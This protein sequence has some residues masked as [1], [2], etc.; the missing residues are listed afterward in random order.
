VGPE[1]VGKNGI[2]TDLAAIE[3]AASGVE[4]WLRAAGWR[5]TA[6]TD[7]PLGAEGNPERLFFARNC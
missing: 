6:W 1:R 3:E 5:V 7:S 2:V 4:A